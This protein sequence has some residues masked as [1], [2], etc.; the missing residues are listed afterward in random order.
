MAE[1]SGLTVGFVGIGNMG[2]PMAACLAR[3]GFH[4][5][6]F[7]IRREAVEGFIA[8]HGRAH[9]GAASLAELARRSDIVIT[10]LPDGEIVRRVVLGDPARSTDCLLA[11]LDPGKVLIDMSS[12][13]PAGTAALGERLDQHGIHLLDAPVSGGLK[14]AATGE[15]AIMVGGDAETIEICEPVLAAMGER[16]FC[17]GKLGSGQ[18]MK[19][20]NNLVSAAGFIAGIEA[21]LIG[22]RF[23]LDSALMVDILNASTGRN[24]STEKK[25]A[26]FVLSRRFDSG[27][28]IALMVK[29][30]T[31]AIELAGETA[32]PAPFS[33][34]CRELWADAEK[35]V[36]GDADHTAVARWFETEAKTEILPGSP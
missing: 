17:T 23:G 5:C 24:N 16:I 18:A 19:A 3:A 25:F 29:D 4:L 26:P 30:I 2:R 36:G 33:A 22:Q 20:L 10:M 35:L 28:T 9:E 11:G 21:L 12:S 32:T 15:L 27:F 14:K 1:A 6:L 34:L 7:D 31:T 13:S 8:E